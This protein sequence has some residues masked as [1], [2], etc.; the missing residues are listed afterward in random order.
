MFV[1]ITDNNLIQKYELSSGVNYKGITIY[2]KH[3]NYYIDLKIG[4]YFDDN[5]KSKKLEIKKYIVIAYQKFLYHMMT[6]QVNYQ[7]L[8]HQAK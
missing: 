5:S 6:Q 8:Y 4:Y 2:N 7:T 3:D 1:I